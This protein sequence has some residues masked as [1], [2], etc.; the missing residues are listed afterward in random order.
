LGLYALCGEDEADLERR[1]E[2]L[3]TA[4]PAGVIDNVSLA[5][6]R[7]G[8]LVGTVPEVRAQVDEWEALGSRRSSWASARCPSTSETPTTSSCSPALVG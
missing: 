4:T 1:F 2:R 6:W 3:K 5:Q 8:R 7:Q